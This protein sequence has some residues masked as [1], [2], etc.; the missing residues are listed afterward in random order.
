MEHTGGKSHVFTFSRR[1][2]DVLE[3][4]TYALSFVHGESTPLSS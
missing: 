2:E 3:H 1:E 4:T